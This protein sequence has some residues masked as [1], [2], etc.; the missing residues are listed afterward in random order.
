[1]GSL[2]T[3]LS[4]L[5]NTLLS[6][7]TLAVMLRFLLQKLGADYY[8][9]LTQLV[10]RA[11]DPVLRPMH[12]VMPAWRGFDLAA[13]VL[14]L[15][16]QAINVVLL[17]LIQGVGML[18]PFQIPFFAAIKLITLFIML[19]IFTILVQVVISW[20][21]PGN[22]N[23]VLGALWTINRPVLDP[24]RRAMPNLGGIDISPMLVLI[25]LFFLNLLVQQLFLPTFLLRL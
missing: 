4:F 25:G 12:K 15:I 24:V 1:M 20:L 21:S 9:P 18:D 6:L 17:A 13:V 11:T 2:A 14:M 8:N 5:V 10:I 16:L 3:P 7:Y 22:P 23:P 19:Y